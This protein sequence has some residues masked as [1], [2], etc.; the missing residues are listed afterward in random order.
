[1]KNTVILI[2]SY[3]PDQT[4]FTTVKGL[5][6]SEFPILI[7]NDGSSKEFDP[8]FESVKE[9]ATVLGYEQNKGKGG[10][11]KYGYSNVLKYY[12][13]AQFVITV[14]G[15]GQHALEDVIHIH[16]LLN[17]HDEIIYGVRHFEG[18]VPLKSK[19]GN[20]FSRYTRTLLTKDY[21]VD[22]QCGLRG[23]PVRYLDELAMVSGERYEYEM[24]QITLFELKG[25]KNYQVPIKTIYLDDN[26]KTHFDP[27][28]DTMRIQSRILLHAIPALICNSLLIF[29]IIFGLYRDVEWFMIVPLS[30]LATFF[31]YMCITL[32]MYTNRKPGKAFLKEGLFFLLRLCVGTALVYLFVILL[33]WPYGLMVP[34][35]VILTVHIN[36]LGGLVKHDLL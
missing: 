25:Y 29:L 2:P 20:W 26:N 19:M 30:Y 6:D 24:N 14:D 7:V 16:D 18:K 36:L 12:P 33:H 27:F 21:L 3:E 13:D 8:V 10:A 4:L 5:Y 15:D 31:L 9:F 11:L 32:F 35:I 28:K 34:L 22:D 1:M 23:F 17:I